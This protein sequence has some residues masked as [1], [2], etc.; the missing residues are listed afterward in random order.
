[1]VD[2]N[3]APYMPV[4]HNPVLGFNSKLNGKRAQSREGKK[5]RFKSRT[6][7]KNNTQYNTMLPNIS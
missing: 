3:A 6:N 5:K 4:Y 7:V 1:M 2:K